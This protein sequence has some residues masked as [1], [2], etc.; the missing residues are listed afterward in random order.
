MIYY[1]LR[2]LVE[3][4]VVRGVRH[5]FAVAGVVAV[6]ALITVG[7]VFMLAPPLLS[8]VSRLQDAVD[9]YVGGGQ[10]LLR[11][12][13]QAL[14]ERAPVLKRASLGH[15]VDL[16]IKQFTDQFAERHLGKLTIQA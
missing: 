14:E 6:V 1:C 10:N 15:K 12:T 3:S 4:L 8:K 16:Q 7:I 9:H 11:K 13:I 5:E 2:P